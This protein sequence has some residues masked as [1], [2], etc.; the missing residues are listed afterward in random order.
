MFWIL[1]R[2]PCLWDNQVFSLSAG[3]NSLL[4]FFSPL[5]LNHLLPLLIFS[6]FFSFF[7]DIPSSDLFSHSYFS[8]VSPFPTY[9]FMLSASFSSFEIT[10]LCLVFLFF[11]FIAIQ[12]DSF[13]LLFSPSHFVHVLFLHLFFLVLNFTLTPTNPAISYSLLL[14]L[15]SILILFGPFLY[16]FPPL[17]FSYLSPSPTIKHFT[18]NYSLPLPFREPPP[19][20]VLFPLH[21]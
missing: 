19:S 21:L 11:F 17:L 12:P 15:F 8:W 14:K 7:L 2:K 16:F 3:F 20:L 5:T 6:F 10:C 9:S 18:Q 1:T 4:L 13:F